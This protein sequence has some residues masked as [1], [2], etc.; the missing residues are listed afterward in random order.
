MDDE[1]PGLSPPYV[2]YRTLMTQIERMESEG[3]PSKIDKHFLSQMA[4]GTQNHFRQA[5]RSLGLIDEDSRPTQSLYDLVSE[6]QRR[7]ELFVKI[8]TD[9][10]PAMYQLP[11]DTSKSDF[12]AVLSSYGV[13]S[14]EQQ[15]KILTFY[16]AAADAAGMTVSTHIRPTKSHTG[17]RR[18]STRR[19]RKT[20]GSAGTP[21]VDS[22]QVSSGAPAEAILSEEAMR[23]MYFKLL[24]EKAEKADHDDDLLDRIER[25]VGIPGR[26][27]NEGSGG[28][29]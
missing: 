9:R 22:S 6:R 15:R 12:F 2:S 14:A 27:S 16:V 13:N 5:L 11:P 25:L 7:A 17:P 29:L 20:N 10:F 28:S 23:G 1:V 19:T 24:L 21:A 4:G 8:M 3:V 26:D 18:P